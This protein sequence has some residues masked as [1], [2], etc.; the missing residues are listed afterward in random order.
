M[1][2]IDFDDN[3]EL[4][5]NISRL[6]RYS[7]TYLRNKYEDSQIVKISPKIKQNLIDKGFV[8]PKLKIDFKNSDSKEEYYP[9]FV[10]RYNV[11]FLIT[12]QIDFLRHK[13]KECILLKL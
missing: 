5:K 1:K 7:L 11:Y 3:I 10:V 6:L 12:P 4:F 2:K 9:I 8:N 13:P